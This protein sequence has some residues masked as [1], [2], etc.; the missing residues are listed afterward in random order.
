MLRTIIAALSATASLVLS[1]ALPEVFPNDP[2]IRQYY[3]TLAVYAAFALYGLAALLF[4]QERGW[5]EQVKS[6]FLDNILR[7]IRRRPTTLLQVEE[8][9]RLLIEDPAKTLHAEKTLRDQF[10]RSLGDY[11][12]AVNGASKEG[13]GLPY[14]GAQ[15]LNYLAQTAR[16]DLG[17]Y[18]EECGIDCPWSFHFTE[19]HMLEIGEQSPQMGRMNLASTAA[20]VARHCEFLAEFEKRAET[21]RGHSSRI[22]VQT[23]MDEV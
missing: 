16:G 5:L 10:E 11:R 14:T 8:S 20:F 4:A 22:R 2:A 19:P 3:A 17:M 15:Q 6:W 9:E 13:A 7:R 23:A 1:V 12:D 21:L 18:T